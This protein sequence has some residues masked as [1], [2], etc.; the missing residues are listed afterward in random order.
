MCGTRHFINRKIQIGALLL[1]EGCVIFANVSSARES[2]GERKTTAE[3]AL[4][5][6]PRR[7]ARKGRWQVKQVSNPS[8]R[9]ALLQASRPSEVRL[10]VRSRR[11]SRKTRRSGEGLAPLARD[12]RAWAAGHP[13]RD[14]RLARARAARDAAPVGSD[15]GGHGGASRGA[16]R[17]D[18]SGTGGAVV[19]DWT[20][21][22]SGPHGPAVAGIGGAVWRAALAETAEACPSC[23]RPWSGRD[24]CPSLRGVRP[25][26]ARTR[27]RRISVQRA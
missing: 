16:R 19:R 13:A 25:C 11:L 1:F 2:T 6:E 21:S 17:P 8:G 26:P 20:Y 5:S 12:A 15:G 7:P 9:P 23:R 10:S 18:R 3:P 27:K 22:G 24:L 4:K 14:R